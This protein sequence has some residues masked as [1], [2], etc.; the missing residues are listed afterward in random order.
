MAK[1]YN[2]HI[3]FKKKIYLLLNFILNDLDI[4]H[5]TIYFEIIIN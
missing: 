5:Y 4:G 2:I 3:T 1:K